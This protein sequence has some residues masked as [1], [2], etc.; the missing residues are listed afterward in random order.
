MIKIDLKHDTYNGC[1]EGPIRMYVDRKRTD[2]AALRLLDLRAPARLAA[3]GQP[4]TVV[5]HRPTGPVSSSPMTLLRPG[6]APGSVIGP[7]SDEP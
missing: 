5:Y 6:Y 2:T 7:W 3:G 1:Q 4:A